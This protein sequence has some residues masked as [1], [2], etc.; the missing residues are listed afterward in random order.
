M[1]PAPDLLAFAERLVRITRTNG[2][3][4]VIDSVSREDGTLV[5]G[6][7]GE[8]WWEGHDQIS[9]IF[10]VQDEEMGGS[11]FAD[12]TT[13]VEEIAAWKESSV[14]WISVRMR[15]LRAGH[16]DFVTRITMVLHEEGAQWRIVQ[17]HASAGVDNEVILGRALTTSIND[18]LV[19]VQDSPP[20]ASSVG[21]DGD[22]TIVFT[23]VKDSTSSLEALGEA[24]WLDLLAWHDGVVA[25]Q[26][27]TFGGAVVKG[28][29]DG[30]MLAFSA[31]G[32]AAA[33]CVAIQR[34]LAG[35]FDGLS[36][37]VRVGVHCG[38]TKVEGG[39]FFGRTVVVAARL[40]G[41]AEGGEILVSQAVHDALGGAF[42]LMGPR[43]LALKGLSG[44]FPAYSLGWA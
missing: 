36:V 6:M 41:A 9:A 18:L 20:P 22:V 40:A 19:A 13:D 11:I 2:V 17:W 29:G 30:F 42:T 12:V 43:S 27:A 21:A 8:E 23:D 7:D 38:N 5:I 4:S 44:D 1:E 31:P 3:S 32:S 37:S 14:G 39:D 33:C 16:S 34:A 10:R 26:T 28:Q 25:R 35:G 15:T 24:R